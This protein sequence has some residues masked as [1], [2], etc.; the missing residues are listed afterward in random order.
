MTTLGAW[1]R[2]LGN[3]GSMSGR[4]YTSYANDVS[5]LSHIHFT[6]AVDHFEF[7]SAFRC[8]YRSYLDRGLLAPCRRGMR[9]ARFHLLPSTRVFVARI[10]RDVVGTVSLVEHGTLGL[11]MQVAFGAEIDELVRHEPRIAEATG[12]AVRPSSRCGLDIIHHLLGLTMQAASRRGMARLLI[13]VHPRHAPF[14]IRVAGF[15][16]LGSSRPHPNV[17]GAGRGL[18]TQFSNV[19]RGISGYFLPLFWHA[20]LTHCAVDRS[21]RDMAIEIPGFALAECA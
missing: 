12:L 4:V 13:A 19:A 11:P 3:I 21:G 2:T 14:Y 6:R 16:I 10:Y 7:E 17:G 5:K 20:I 15:R 1:L 18:G 8:L 9:L